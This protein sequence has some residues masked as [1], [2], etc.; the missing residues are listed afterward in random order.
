[1]VEAI[2]NKNKKENILIFG[3]PFADTLIDLEYLKNKYLNVSLASEVISGN[4]HAVIEESFIMGMCK[5]LYSTKATG[6]VR[7]ALKINSK[8]NVV[9]FEDYFDNKE[10]DKILM[11]GLNNNDYNSLQRANHARRLIYIRASDNSELH[12]KLNSLDPI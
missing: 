6:V 12:E 10:L 7:L 11:F 4:L 9:Y 1:M 2:I 8:L 5:E 3:T